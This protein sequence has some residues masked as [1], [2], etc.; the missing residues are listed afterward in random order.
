M[1]EKKALAMLGLAQKAGKAASGEFAVESAVK[2]GK[3]WLVIVANDASANTKKKMTDMTGFYEIPIC[4]LGTKDTLGQSMGKEY[5]SM[6]AVLDENFS[7]AILKK[8]VNE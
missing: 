5:R 4:F 3:A 2:S 7:A 8:L 6:A 1:D